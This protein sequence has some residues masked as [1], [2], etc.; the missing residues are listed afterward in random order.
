MTGPGKL[1]KV[2]TLGKIFPTCT[3][4]PNFAGILFTDWDIRVKSDQ[5][6]MT[7]AKN[8]IA[9]KLC[10]ATA[11]IPTEKGRTPFSIS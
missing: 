1:L 2:R 11:I 3:L 8:K 4:M 9:R 10:K 5:W 6:A 7:E